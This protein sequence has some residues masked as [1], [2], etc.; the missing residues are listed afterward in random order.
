MQK[1]IKDV[2]PLQNYHPGAGREYRIVFE[3][4]TTILLYE[5]VFYHIYGELQSSKDFPTL[6]GTGL[7]LDTSTVL[8]ELF[9]YS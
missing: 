2:I 1:V 6:I 9:K 4:N 8:Q 3:D 5:E 7:D